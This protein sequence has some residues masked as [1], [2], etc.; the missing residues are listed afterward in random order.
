MSTW[1]KQFDK[2]IN[3]SKG[4][5]LISLHDLLSTSQRFPKGSIGA[6]KAIGSFMSAADRR[7]PIMVAYIS[8]A[9]SIGSKR[10]GVHAKSQKLEA[11]LASISRGTC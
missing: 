11:A 6:K 7:L 8:S 1:S 2:P 9:E 10:T 5:Q 3:L 4:G